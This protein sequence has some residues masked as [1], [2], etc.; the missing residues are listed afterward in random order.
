MSMLHQWDMP[1]SETLPV[2]DRLI[3]EEEASVHSSWK[4]QAV[5]LQMWEKFWMWRK[6]EQDSYQCGDSVPHKIL[7]KE[8]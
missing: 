7:M 4:Q 1:E 8:L 6:C 2:C 3:K 5:L